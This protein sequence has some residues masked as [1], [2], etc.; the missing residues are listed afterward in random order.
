MKLQG[1]QHRVFGNKY[2]QEIFEEILGFTFSEYSVE[3]SAVEMARGV[4]IEALKSTIAVA[5]VE[6]KTELHDAIHKATKIESSP[7]LGE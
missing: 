4:G 2:G 5:A 7:Y 6:V 1:Q 3:S